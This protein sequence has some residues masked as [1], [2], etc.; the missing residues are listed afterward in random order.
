MT[1]PEHNDWQTAAGLA[2]AV[3]MTRLVKMARVPGRLSMNRDRQFDAFAEFLA[4]SLTRPA[5]L[6]I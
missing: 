6:R 2:G 5:P 4:R 3:A 1:Q